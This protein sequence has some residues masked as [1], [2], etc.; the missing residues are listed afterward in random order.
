MKIKKKR[1]KIF[2]LYVSIKSQYISL[3]K[4]FLQEGE[5]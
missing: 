3:W 1:M 5:A 2:L 4:R